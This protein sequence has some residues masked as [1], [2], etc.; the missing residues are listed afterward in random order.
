MAGQD[1]AIAVHE[2]RGG[3]ACKL[4]FAGGAAHLRHRFGHMQ[5]AAVGARQHAA[6]GVGRQRAVAAQQACSDRR[7]RLALLAEAQAFQLEQLGHG[8]AVVELRHL[9]VAR[10]EARHLA[11]TPAR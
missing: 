1:A 6:V 2:A 8:E 5:D 9:D 11:R 4:S 7:T 3:P 10:R